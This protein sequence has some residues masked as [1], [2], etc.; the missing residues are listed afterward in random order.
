[1]MHARLRIHHTDLKRAAML[2]NFIIKVCK[3]QWYIVWHG[4]LNAHTFQVK[5]SKTTCYVQ[6]PCSHSCDVNNNGFNYNPSRNYQCSL[7]CEG[8]SCVQTCNVAKYDLECDGPHCKQTC[9]NANG[10]CNL[11][12]YGGAC[13]QTCNKGNCGLECSGIHCVQTC[14]DGT[15]SLKCNGE[16][17]EQKCFG[18]CNLERHGKSCIQNC[19][20]IYNSDG[21]QLHCPVEGHASKCLQNCKNKE[22]L[23]S[24][25]LITITEAPTT[26]SLGHYR[27]WAG[28]WSNASAVVAID[29]ANSW[30]CDPIEKP[31]RLG[32]RLI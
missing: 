4:T 24:K 6:V 32:Q 14:F 31:V 17:C 1:M 12:C 21:C 8:Q 22:F 19:S 5:N 3:L 29:L 10:A 23:C 16:K 13:V 11:N 30:V 18:S 7:D 25:N 15:C 20:E 28:E 27:T 2:V 26:I 9:N